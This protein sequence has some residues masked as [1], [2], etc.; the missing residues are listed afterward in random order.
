MYRPYACYPPVLSLRWEHNGKR[1]VHGEV[2]AIMGGRCP[3][4]EAKR[5]RFGGTDDHIDFSTNLS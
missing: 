4:W 2:E 5:Q 1:Q 3:A